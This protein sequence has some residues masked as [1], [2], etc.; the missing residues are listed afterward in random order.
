MGF[1][2][3]A[4]KVQP[5]RVESTPVQEQA[6]EEEYEEDDSRDFDI[7][8]PRLSLPIDVD[9]SI[10]LPPEMSVLGEDLTQRSVEAG[11]RALT[12]PYMQERSRLSEGAFSIPGGLIQSGFDGPLGQEGSP[13]IGA[14]DASI[15][16]TERQG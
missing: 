9:D 15:F 3:L 6:D 7:P 4:A 2:V 12:E 11:R 16:Q 14:M 8:R 5:A 10:E 1:L 13:G